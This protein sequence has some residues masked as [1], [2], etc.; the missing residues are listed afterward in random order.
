MVVGRS[1]SC[2]TEVGVGL[3]AQF[4]DQLSLE[5]NTCVTTDPG[6]MLKKAVPPVR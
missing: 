3:S 2:V 6:R 5:D 4:S 1:G